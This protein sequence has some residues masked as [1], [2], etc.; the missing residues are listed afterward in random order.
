MV[1]SRR[2]RSSAAEPP[3][4]AIE[5]EKG[6]LEAAIGLPGTGVCQRISDVPELVTATGLPALMTWVVWAVWL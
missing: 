3:S 5:N 2:L 4:I 6:R 1:K